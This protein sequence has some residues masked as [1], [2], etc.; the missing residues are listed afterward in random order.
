MI[1]MLLNGK[2]VGK[3]QPAQLSIVHKSCTPG[4]LV[5][6]VHNKNGTSVSAVFVASNVHCTT[7]LALARLRIAMQ[8]LFMGHFERWFPMAYNSCNVARDFP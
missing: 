2:R 6:A 3:V 1:A 5:G 7:Q 8:T 4:L